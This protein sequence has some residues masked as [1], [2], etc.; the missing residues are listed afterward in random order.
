[1]ESGEFAI[2]RD[3]LHRHQDEDR[4]IFQQ[5]REQQRSDMLDVRTRMDDLTQAMQAIREDFSAWSGA[6]GMAKWALGLGI[7]AILGALITHV[8]RHW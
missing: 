7:P 5:V 3:D 1:M 8:V 2:L 6:I 4:E